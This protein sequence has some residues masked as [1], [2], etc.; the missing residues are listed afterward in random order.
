M[1][2]M[3]EPDD[4]VYYGNSLTPLEEGAYLNFV[5]DV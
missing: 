2:L 5:C 3:E 4:F 1:D